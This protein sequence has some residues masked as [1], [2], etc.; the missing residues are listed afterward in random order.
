MFA[1]QPGAASAHMEAGE[2]D[3]EP[4]QMAQILDITSVTRLQQKTGDIVNRIRI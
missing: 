1:A 4:R 3:S 2:G